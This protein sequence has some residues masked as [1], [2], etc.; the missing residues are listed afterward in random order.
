MHKTPPAMLSYGPMPMY[1]NPHIYLRSPHK[2]LT[3]VAT[4]AVKHPFDYEYYIIH[5]LILYY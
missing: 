3:Y 1:N 5:T 4:A 2:L